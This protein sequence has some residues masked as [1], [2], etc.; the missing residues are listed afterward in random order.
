[1]VRL[2]KEPLRRAAALALALVMLAALPAGAAPALTDTQRNSMAMLNYLTVL[3]QQINASQNSRL[4]LEDAYTTLINNIS[5]NAVDAMTLEQLM[6]LL[7]TMEG[8]RMV[9]V[10]RERMKYLNEQST[11]QKL[12]AALPSPLNI[13][14]IVESDKKIKLA[15]S[16]ASAALDVAAQFLESEEEGRTKYLAEDLGLD[17]EAAAVLHSSRKAAFSYMISVVNEQGL[18]GEMALSENHV[19]TFVE[20]KNNSNVIQRVQFL[21]SNRATYQGFGDYWLVLAESYY[22]LQD[23]AKCLE[24]IDSYGALNVRIFR[25]DHDLARVLPLAVAAAGLSLG[26][27]DYVPYAADGCARILA[28]TDPGEWSLRFFVVHTLAD[29]YGRTGSADYLRQA[30]ELAL[31]NVNSLVGRQRQMNNAY[32]S[33]VAVAA[34]PRDA[35][36]EQRREIDQYNKYLKEERKAEIPPV[37][38]PLVLNCDM[39]FMLAN[40]LGIADSDKAKI[41]GILHENGQ[42]IFLTPSID[43]KYW[44]NRPEGPLPAGA[45]APSF[46]IK[47]LSLPII[48]L[49][50]QAAIRVTVQ[51]ED[52]AAEA[53][54]EDWTLNRVERGTQGDIGSFVA[55]YQSARAQKHAYTP[56]DKV[57]LEVLDG[58]GGQPV[59]TLEFTAVEAKSQWWEVVKVWEEAFTFQPA[60]EPAP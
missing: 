33:E 19:K 42:P 30:Y 48:S 39:L 35:T 11:A 32:L 44:F 52:S 60:E 37:Y 21:E 57:R 16:I 47:E 7:D 24:A 29:L 58:A 55:V 4:Y 6:N 54:Y 9:E 28:N 49:P 20:E 13:L 1:M 2:I 31:D 10:K 3:T 14:N 8:Y 5:P 18:P 27:A 12:M 25:K 43:E 46:T 59:L 26:E 22:H 51:G 40:E 53:V 23:Y 36:K 17:D 15:L 38:E 34:V 45:A 41:D 50:A 56:G